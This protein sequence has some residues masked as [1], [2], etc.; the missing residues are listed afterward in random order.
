MRLRN[1]LRKH[2]P[3]ILAISHYLSQY[4]DPCRHMASQVH[5]E[6][7]HCS[8]LFMH[9]PKW[10]SFPEAMRQTN[11]ATSMTVQQ[12]HFS[13]S[14][15]VKD[16]QQQQQ[17]LHYERIDMSTWQLILC[18]IQWYGWISQITTINLKKGYP[19]IYLRVPDLQ[20]SCSNFA[21]MR[22]Y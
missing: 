13:K 21:N 10:M 5:N 16:K 15:P 17:Q 18:S 3:E 1:I 14:H 4:S 12:K 7:M 8:K 19:Q 20:M 11:C 2:T 9:S 6:W 22:G